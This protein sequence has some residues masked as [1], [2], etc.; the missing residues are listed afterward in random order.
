MF[1]VFWNVN[2]DTEVQ[3]GGSG[4]NHRPSWESGS[5]KH[6]ELKLTLRF[7][8]VI[9]V[10]E[11]KVKKKKTFV[12]CWWNWDCDGM[13]L[14]ASLSQSLTNSFAYVTSPTLQALILRGVTGSEVSICI[15]IHCYCQ[16]GN[17][18]IP[19]TD[20]LTDLV[21]IPSDF[22]HMSASGL[23]INAL[24]MIIQAGIM[25]LL[26]LTYCFQSTQHYELYLE[27]SCPKI[28]TWAKTA[29]INVIVGHKN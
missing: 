2:V 17:F 20:W 29:K 4:V 26:N 9:D 23:R 16:R 27:Q 3:S 15:M 6:A 10:V 21:P 11:L 1:I 12:Q 28:F 7:I 25:Y 8:C 24:V 22:S 14:L 19:L 13:S 5:M 18:K